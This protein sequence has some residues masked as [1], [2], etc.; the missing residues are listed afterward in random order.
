MLKT[1]FFGYVVPI[2]GLVPITGRRLFVDA[3]HIQRKQ[4][5]DPS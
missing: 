2:T 3:I 5:L 4:L 1:F